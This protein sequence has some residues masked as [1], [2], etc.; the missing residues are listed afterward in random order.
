MTSFYQA[1]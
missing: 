1:T